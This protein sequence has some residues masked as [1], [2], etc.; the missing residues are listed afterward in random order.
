METAIRIPTRQEFK[1]AHIRLEQDGWVYTHSI[2]TDS[3]DDLNFGRSY[4]KGVRVFY[5]NLHTIETLPK[6]EG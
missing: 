4:Y 3:K 5:L 1:K 2:M 6:K